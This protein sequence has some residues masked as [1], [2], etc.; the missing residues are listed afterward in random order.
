[1]KALLM[2]NDNIAPQL[3]IDFERELGS[4]YKYQVDKQELL[5]SD[6]TIDKKSITSLK[7]KLIIVNTIV[8]S[9]P[10]RSQKKII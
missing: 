6:F 2:Y 10:T 4:T 3:V 7:P 1:M 5:S 9:F 8:F